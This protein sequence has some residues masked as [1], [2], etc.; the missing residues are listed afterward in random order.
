MTQ[1]CSEPEMNLNYSIVYSKRKTVTIIVERDRSVVVRAPIGT[2][3]EKIDQLINQKSLWLYE[4]TRHKQ[5]Y[6]PQPSAKEFVAGASIPYLGRQYRLD[7]VSESFD[8]ILFD[9][10]F[11]ISKRRAYRA[12]DLFKAWYL[13]RAKQTILPVVKDYGSKT[14][15]RYNNVRISDLKYRWGS[16]T[17]RNNLNFNWRLIKAP[18]RVIE[19]VIVHELAHLLEPNHTERFWQIVRT[20]LPDYARAKQWLKENGSLLEEQP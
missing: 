4:K 20:Q 12:P 11:M 1:S 17:P 15:A 14:G 5:K 18:M 3:A 6:S 2:P 8:G 9:D 19:Y 16:C 10:K 13:E 7:V